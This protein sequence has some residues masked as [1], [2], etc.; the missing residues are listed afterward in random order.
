MPLLA[1]L[2]AA[3][4]TGNDIHDIA[5]FAPQVSGRFIS[6]EWGI[7]L[8]L[9]GSTSLVL[10]SVLLLVE[11]ARTPT[12]AATR[13]NA[14]TAS[15]PGA[16]PSPVAGQTSRSQTPAAARSLRHRLDRLV[17]L[18]ALRTNPH[19]TRPSPHEQ[20]RPTMPPTTK[21]RRRLSV[22]SGFHFKG[23]NAHA[24]K[25]LSPI[26]SGVPA[27]CCHARHPPPP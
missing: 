17:R 27:R 2:T 22:R 18:L 4:L 11:P 20:H 5:D 8:A 21:A 14:C 23:Q 7:Y 13:R 12:P 19:P 16:R 6:V 15:R 3:A 9:F 10:A 25:F 1:G 24:S 26:I